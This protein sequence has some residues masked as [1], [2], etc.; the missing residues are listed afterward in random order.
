MHSEAKGYALGFFVFGLIMPGIDNAAHAGG[1]IGGYFAG[2][3]LDPLKPQSLW[4]LVGALACLV[5]TALAII[6]SIVTV[7]P[8][9]IRPLNA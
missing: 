6:A 4:H 3:M 2:M 8:I 5:L 7:C 1:F 9:L